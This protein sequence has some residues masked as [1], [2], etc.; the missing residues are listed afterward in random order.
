MGCDLSPLLFLFFINSVVDRLMQEDPDR[1]QQLV[2]A[3]FADDVTVLARHS[4][5]DLAT[6]EAQWAVDIIAEWSKE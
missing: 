1:A 2:L 6:A 4:S 3:L 5:R